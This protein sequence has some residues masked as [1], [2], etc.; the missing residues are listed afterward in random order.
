[1]KSTAYGEKKAKNKNNWTSRIIHTVMLAK[2]S[3]RERERERESARACVVVIVLCVWHVVTWSATKAN[4]LRDM[5]FTSYN[6][7]R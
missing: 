5:L 2:E 1:L 6:T 4:F 3:E 7:G